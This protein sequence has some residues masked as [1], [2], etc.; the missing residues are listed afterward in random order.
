MRSHIER[1]EQFVHEIDRTLEMKPE[2]RGA[3]LEGVEV[4]AKVY[5]TNSEEMN[6]AKL[7]EANYSCRVVLSF[8]QTAKG[9]KNIIP[10]RIVVHEYLAQ[11]ASCIEPRKYVAEIL[12]QF[13]A[14]LNSRN[15]GVEAKLDG[16]KLNV[17]RS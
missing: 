17:Y 5:P 2:E 7:S 8:V 4:W 1:I 6:A 10:K 3:G 12:Q 15:N 11:I 13:G 14:G 16:G 9:Q